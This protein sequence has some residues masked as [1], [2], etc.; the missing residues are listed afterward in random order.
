M[1][2]PEVPVR[3]EDLCPEG[4]R[5]VGVYPWV[6]ETGGILYETVRYEHLTDKQAKKPDK[7]EKTFRVRRPVPDRP[8]MYL[9]SR[10]GIPPV[11]F[12]KDRL[13]ARPDDDRHWAEGEEQVLALE[14]LGLLATTTTHGAQAVRAYSAEALRSAARGRNVVLH[15]DNDPDG[16]FYRSFVAGTI[17]SVARSIRVVRYSDF[18]P[19]G[20]VLDFFRA[21]G[22]RE[23]L[24]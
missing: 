11:V 23:E 7:P 12:R 19:G 17:A 24:E 4:F 3:E 22:T 16:E 21:G 2:T 9:R 13:A 8:G 18:G 15:Q 14:E 5:E 10:G 1:A 20:D 6:D